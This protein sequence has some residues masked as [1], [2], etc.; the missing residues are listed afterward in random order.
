MADQIIGTM[1]PHSS[2][3][4]PGCC[5]CLNGVI[6]GESADIVCNE[7]GAILKTIPADQLK[8]VFHEMEL[9]LDLASAICP[10]CGAAHIA[11][12]MSELH[13]FVCE[14]CGQGVTLTQQQERD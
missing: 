3:G 12:G 4:D 13:A 11:P 5:G 10:Y 8:R 6:R 2:F 9:S 7:C 1:L 14:N